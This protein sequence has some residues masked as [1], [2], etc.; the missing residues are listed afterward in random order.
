MLRVLVLLLVL[1]NTAY[2]SWS[3]G[4]LAG[5]GLQPAGQSEPQRLE[6]QIRPELL[7]IVPTPENQPAQR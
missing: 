4:L 6:Q 3:Q 5:L 2:F 7:R 1:A